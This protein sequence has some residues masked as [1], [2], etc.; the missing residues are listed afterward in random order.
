VKAFL[1]VLLCVSSLSL[2]S[3]AATFVLVHG[4]F[5]D[6]SVWQEV[7]KHLGKK[8]HEVIS[9]DLPGRPSNPARPEEVSAEKYRD[10]IVNAIG[11]RP[12]VI[13]AGHSFGGIQISNVA[14]AIPQQIHALVYI[15]AYLPRD[16]ESLQALSAADKDSKVGASFV[17][18]PD[19]KTAS[20]K[21]S[22]AVSLFCADCRIPSAGRAAGAH[23]ATRQA[24]GAEFRH[25]ETLLRHYT[26]RCCSEHFQAEGD[27]YG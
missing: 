7:K 12:H 15:A 13:L 27:V 22:E 10:A 24:D 3:S 26:P 16:S 25:G 19:Y 8:G 1:S 5:E 9:V 11:S 17:V 6:A 14:E 21:A 2:R 4:A 23:G 18:S 20:I